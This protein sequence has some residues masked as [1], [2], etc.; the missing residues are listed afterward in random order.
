MDLKNLDIKI[1]LL[2]V[3]LVLLLIQSIRI[4]ILKYR[5]NSTKKK[6]EN[7]R[8]EILVQTTEI[9]DESYVKLN[10]E[11]KKLKEE[12]EQLKTEK[13]NMTSHINN[14]NN[15]EQNNIEAQILNS[16]IEKIKSDPRTCTIFMSFW[17][18]ALDE[19]RKEYEDSTLGKK[20]FNFVTL[21]HLREPNNNIESK[22]ID[23]IEDKS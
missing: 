22:K 3:V 5:L 7:K 18:I 1:I 9:R 2:G 11:N 19:A 12:I 4:L 6:E 17:P 13:A 15:I 20:I 14:L 8:K 21:K 10:D 23:S 16:A